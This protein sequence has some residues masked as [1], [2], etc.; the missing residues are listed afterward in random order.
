[1]K[2]AKDCTLYY[3]CNFFFLYYRIVVRIDKWE[4]TSQYPDG[5]FVRT[6]GPI[7]NVEVSKVYMDDCYHDNKLSKHIVK[8]M[9]R[10]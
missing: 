2:M 5:H 9:C 10:Y 4:A 8:E 3:V 6:I 1:M 7:G